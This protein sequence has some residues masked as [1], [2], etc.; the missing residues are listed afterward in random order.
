MAPK[1]IRADNG[2][3]FIAETGQQWLRDRGGQPVFVEKASVRGQVNVPA[4][5][6]V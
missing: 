4:G 1:M 3:E 5:G 6:Q 2:R